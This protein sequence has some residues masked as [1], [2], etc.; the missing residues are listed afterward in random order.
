ML[1]DRVDLAETI[2]FG[3]R[4]AEL[5]HA[6]H[7]ADVALARAAFDD[8]LI[9]PHR[10]DLVPGFAT[11]QRAAKSA[12]AIGCSL[13]GSGPATIA[14]AADGETAREVAKAMEAAYREAGLDVT[15]LTARVETRGA[16]VI[17][18]DTR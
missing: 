15:S 3:R 6:L 7:E 1:P 17:G 18:E 10:A 8:T 16:R 4:L 14:V 11:A 12:G 13:S 2:A 5:T 9:E